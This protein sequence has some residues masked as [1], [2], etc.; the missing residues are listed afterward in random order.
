[1]LLL[2]TLNVEI[3]L[4]KTFLYYQNYDGTSMEMGNKK[5]TLLLITKSRY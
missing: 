4:L 1:M 3:R 2:I 5:E